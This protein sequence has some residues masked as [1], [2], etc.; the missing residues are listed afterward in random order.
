MVVIL[1][2]TF[3]FFKAA[4]GLRGHSQALHCCVQGLVAGSRGY[5]CCE[6]TARPEGLPSPASPHLWSCPMGRLALP[7]ALFSCGGPRLLKASGMVQSS[8]LLAG[9]PIRLGGDWRQKASIQKQA[10]L[11]TRLPV[12]WAW[13]GFLGTAGLHP[14]GC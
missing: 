7:L 12:S 6:G 3:F 4:M 14:A 9:H 8:P 11:N 13:A 2:I 1:F 10:H 5:S